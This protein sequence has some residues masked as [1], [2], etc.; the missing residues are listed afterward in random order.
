[1]TGLVTDHPERVVEH[2]HKLSRW[3]E[4]PW[5][6]LLTV[7]GAL[8]GVW[9]KA[10]HKSVFWHRLRDGFDGKYQ[11]ETLDGLHKDLVTSRDAGQGMLG[12]GAGDGWVLTDWFENALLGIAPDVYR[13]L[14]DN[15]VS[16]ESEQVAEALQWLGEVWSIDNVL[17]DEPQRALLTQYDQAAIQ[18]LGKHPGMGLTFEGDFIAPALAPYQKKNFVDLRLG[19][20]RFPPKEKGAERPLVVGGDFAVLLNTG[21]QATDGKASDVVEWLAGPDAARSFAAHGFLTIHE[22]TGDAEYL[23]SVPGWLPDGSNLPELFRELA[24]QLRNPRD[25]A[26][27]FDLSDQ[28][29]GRLSGGDGQGIWRLLQNFFSEVTRPGADINMAVDDA[30]RALV[31]AAG[32]A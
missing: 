19:T 6:D 23:T 28:L 21:D 1:L 30:Q 10:T 17:F 7:S 12:V 3:P 5:W 8:H 4:W 14:T 31:A 11:P 15:S 24:C 13:G 26:V 25:S 29:K 22:E 18:V 2:P 9:L 32:G 27:A 20:F 16:W